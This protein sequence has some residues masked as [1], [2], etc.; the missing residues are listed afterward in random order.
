MF[1]VGKLLV[2]IIWE[3]QRKST[4]SKLPKI[5]ETASSSGVEK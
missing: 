1:P 4:L 5:L 3:G 2:L